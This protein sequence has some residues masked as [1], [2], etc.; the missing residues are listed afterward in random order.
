[1]R[2]EMVEI[3]RNLICEIRGPCEVSDN[4]FDGISPLNLGDAIKTLSYLI[5]RCDFLVAS[6]K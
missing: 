5:I 2:N 4:S 3:A 1:M 6:E